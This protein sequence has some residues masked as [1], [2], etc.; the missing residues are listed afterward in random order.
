[1]WPAKIPRGR[2]KDLDQ[3]PFWSVTIAGNLVIG[4]EMQIAQN[5][6]GSLY[7]VVRVPIRINHLS[8]FFNRATAIKPPDRGRADC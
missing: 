1:M 3:N 4:T 5:P 7:N 2:E 6:P 8:I